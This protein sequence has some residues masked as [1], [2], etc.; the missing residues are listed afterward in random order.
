M[1]VDIHFFDAIKI[2]VLSWRALVAL[3]ILPPSYPSQIAS[4]AVQTARAAKDI[5]PEKRRKLAETKSSPHYAQSNGNA[6]AGVKSMENLLKASIKASELGVDLF[7]KALMSYRNTPTREDRVSPTMKLYER[8]LQDRVITHS[9]AFLQCWGD[10]AAAAGEYANHSR[11][12]MKTTYNK[13]TKELPKLKVGEHNKKYTMRTPSGRP[14]VGNRYHIRQSAIDKA[15][16]KLSPMGGPGN[17]YFWQGE[18]EHGGG[19]PPREM[20]RPRRSPRRQEQLI[21]EM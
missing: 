12:K 20:E 15:P 17:P 3:R 7:Q 13:G 1:L 19:P 9:R 11:S 18:V 4:L 5:K 6:E 8:Q 21:E 10:V 16:E 14:F 2:P